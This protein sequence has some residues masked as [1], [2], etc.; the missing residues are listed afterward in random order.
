[1]GDAGNKKKKG[2]PDNKSKVKS[3]YQMEK[4]TMSGKHKKEKE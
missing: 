3:E 2:N 1:M 4:A